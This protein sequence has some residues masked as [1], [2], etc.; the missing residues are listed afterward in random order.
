[1]GTEKVEKTGLA[2]LLLGTLVEFDVFEFEIFAKV[3]F[4]KPAVWGPQRDVGLGV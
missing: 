4:E 3:G 2:W 1:M